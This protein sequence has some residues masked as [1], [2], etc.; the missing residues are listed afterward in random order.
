M[1]PIVCD[2]LSDAPNHPE[3]MLMLD[4]LGEGLLPPIV[5]HKQAYYTGR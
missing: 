5:I 1:M 2:E 4:R 3:V